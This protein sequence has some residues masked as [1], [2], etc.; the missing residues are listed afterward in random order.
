MPKYET[1][2]PKGWGGDPSRGAALGRTNIEEMKNT[3]DDRLTLRRVPLN[4]GGYD[5]LGTYW[6]R[7]Q[8]LYWCANE[9]GTLEMT[10]RADD[11][12]HAKHVILEQYPNVRFYR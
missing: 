10:F 11:R 4:V 1:N 3:D 2:D 12:E 9:E 5:R 7:G 6:G 8:P